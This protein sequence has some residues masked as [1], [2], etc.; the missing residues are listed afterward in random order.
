MAGFIGY[1]MFDGKQV[2]CLR[3]VGDA[4]F[5]SRFFCVQ[6][7]KQRLVSMHHRS[8]QFEV[9]SCSVDCS[10]RVGPAWCEWL[11]C[12]IRICHDELQVRPTFVSEEWVGGDKGSTECVKHLA[13]L[14]DFVTDVGFLRGVFL[15]RLFVCF[16]LNK[17]IQEL[18]AFVSMRSGSGGRWVILVLCSNRFGVGMRTEGC[19]VR[20]PG[21]C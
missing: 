17:F 10:E 20:F 2:A 16:S 5:V 18:F 12:Q 13:F 4:L 8:V 3:Y 1:T 6:C 14:D 11:D 7:L 19:S 9:A 21:G 15:A